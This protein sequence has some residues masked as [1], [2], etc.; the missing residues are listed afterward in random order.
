MGVV[1][2]GEEIDLVGYDSSGDNASHSSTRSLSLILF[3][4]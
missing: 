1:M 2:K 4:A 3:S